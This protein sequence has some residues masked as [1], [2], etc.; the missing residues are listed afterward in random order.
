MLT[1]VELGLDSLF[2]V[3]INLLTIGLGRDWLTHVELG[4]DSLFLDDSNLLTIGL[5]RRDWLLF[6][7]RY[8]SGVELDRDRILSEDVDVNAL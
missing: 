7:D 4:L 6:A 1:H 2:L 3:N 5:G 8:K